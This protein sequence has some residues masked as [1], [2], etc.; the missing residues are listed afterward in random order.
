LP[1]LTHGCPAR[2]LL[3]KRTALILLVL[4]RRQR[5][6]TREEQRRAASE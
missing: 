2:F 6:G 1:G 4:G 5:S 3:T